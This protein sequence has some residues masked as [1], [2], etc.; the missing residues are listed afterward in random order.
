MWASMEESARAEQSQEAEQK[1]KAFRMTF[2]STMVA[3]VSR[4][5][6]SSGSES[7]TQSSEQQRV[8]GASLG[9]RP[10]GPEFGLDWCPSPQVVGSRPYP[11]PTVAL[12]RMGRNEVPPGN[13]I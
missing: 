8:G 5:D 11:Q 10:S 12:I 2:M 13:Q 9:R 1:G 4:S 6:Y 7:L 3:G